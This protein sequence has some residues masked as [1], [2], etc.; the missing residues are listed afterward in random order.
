MRVY[1]FINRKY[2]LQ[3]LRRKRLK[4]S[5]IDQLNDPF[6]M[7]G[8]ASRNRDERQAFAEVK[9]GLARYSGVLCFSGNW[10]N[11]VQ[12]SHYADR[13]KGLCLG[14]DVP[15]ALLTRV[16]YRSK[17]LK[18]DPQA[19]KE[20]Q[21]E[22][23]AAQEMMLNLVTT[24]FSH[25]RYEHEHRMFVRLEE[26]DARGLY[27]CDFSENLALREAIVGSESSISRAQLKR[28][29]GRMSTC[30]VVFKARLAFQ[31]FRVVRQ[32]RDALWK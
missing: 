7:V 11:P 31:S 12:W 27:F 20:M 3:A 8:F 19:I 16:K 2:G 9:A 10:S 21:A 26:R 18:P 22:G 29:L 6:E 1:H 32:K 23:A 28:A 5:L 13:H 17:R 30:V 14:F 25:W 15:E 4:V 24:K